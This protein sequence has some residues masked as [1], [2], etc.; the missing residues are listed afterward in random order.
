V[1]G[2]SKVDRISC[3]EQFLEYKKYFDEQYP[4]YL[5]IRED[6]EKLQQVKKKTKKNFTH[7]NSP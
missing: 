6:L 3:E 7:L 5:K 4:S 1:D 2:D